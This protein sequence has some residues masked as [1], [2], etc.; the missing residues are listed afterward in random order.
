MVGIGRCRRRDRYRA[1]SSERGWAGRSSAAAGYRPMANETKIQRL[2]S[3]CLGPQQPAMLVD[4]LPWANHGGML[5]VTIAARHE[6]RETTP[7]KIRVTIPP[8]SP[9][10]TPPPPTPCAQRQRRS[11]SR[12]TVSKTGRT[13]SR[14]AEGTTPFGSGPWPLRSTCRRRRRRRPIY[15]PR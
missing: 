13:G 8:P 6:T 9:S 1:V 11:S 5:H 14:R 4:K 10:L 12:S 2:C 3:G 15:L 7:L